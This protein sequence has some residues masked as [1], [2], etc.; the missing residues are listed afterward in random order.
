MAAKGMPALSWKRRM[1]EAQLLRAMKRTLQDA[2]GDRLRGVVLFGSRA[3]GDGGPD[4]DLDLLVLLEAPVRLGEDLERTIVAL[5]PL[6]LECE[7][8]IHAVPV[9][10][11][12]F[13]SGEFG[14][15]RHAKDEGVYL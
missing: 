9:D 8:P 7:Q 10:F 5:Y 1:R 11:R 4:S 15:Y 13:E 2:F 3:R 12:T 14:W 6:Q